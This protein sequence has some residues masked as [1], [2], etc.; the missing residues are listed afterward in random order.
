MIYITK[1]DS[2]AKTARASH[3]NQLKSACTSKLA[4]LF[5]SKTS[6]YDY[7]FYLK[8][9]TALV[10]RWHEPVYTRDVSIAVILNFLGRVVCLELHQIGFLRSNSSFSHLKRILLRLHFRFPRT[11]VVVLTNPAA[12]VLR[13]YFSLSEDR[14]HVIPDAGRPIYSAISPYKASIE[15]HI[16]YA[17]SFEKG[18]G[19]LETLHIA[20]HNSNFNF[21]TAGHLTHNAEKLLEKLENVDH[22]GYLGQNELQQFLQTSHILLAPASPRVYI[23]T[24]D[25]TFYTSPLKLYQYLFYPV[26][27]VISTSQVNKPLLG[28]PHVYPV[29]MT[30]TSNK[31]FPELFDYLF[32]KYAEISPNQIYADR[33][34]YL[35]SWEKRLLDMSLVFQ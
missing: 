27:I 24:N 35:Y 34:P 25:I 19:G 5:I 32:T 23:G 6:K 26:P 8:V 18:K 2:S 3:F 29:N 14:V 21:K 28:I 15:R 7:L 13:R 1:L 31:M 10:K 17:G 16:A 11:L 22:V 12:R 33:N 30:D 4:I 20:A 9:V